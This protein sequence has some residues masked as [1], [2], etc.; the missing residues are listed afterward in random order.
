MASFSPNPHQMVISYPYYITVDANESRNKPQSK[1]WLIVKEA[2]FER[3]DLHI[4][5][6]YTSLLTA[7]V[8]GNL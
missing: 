8:Q 4:R 5:S 2:G 1:H 3:L 6:V 7:R